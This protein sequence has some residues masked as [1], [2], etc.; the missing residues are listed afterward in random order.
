[1]QTKTNSG[2][3]SADWTSHS[4]DPKKVCAAITK[5]TKTIKLV[6]K[7]GEVTV[8]VHRELLCF[9]SSYYRAALKGNFSE[10]KTDSLIVDLSGK[11]LKDFVTWIYTGEIITT[12]ETCDARLY[13]FGDQVDSLALRRSVLNE[14]HGKD[15]LVRYEVI[16]ILLSNLPEASALRKWTLARY[17]NHWKPEDD[18]TDPCLLDTVNDPGY[19]LAN[20]VYQVLRGVVNREEDDSGCYCCQ[21]ACNYHEH[22]S[23]EEWEATCGQIEDMEMPED[24]E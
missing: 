2:S 18:E 20:F 24:I 14:M 15:A 6:S 19:N 22:E 4:W 11:N 12:D 17:I 23:K 3:A 10:A 21:N 9:F 1:M 7:T 5:S 8:S 13:V 16:E